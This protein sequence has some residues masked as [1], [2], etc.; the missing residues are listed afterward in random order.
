MRINAKKLDLIARIIEVD[1]EEILA[2]IKD[3]L[4]KNSDISTVLLNQEEEERIINALHESEA[5]YKAGSTHSRKDVE[6]YFNLKYS[7]IKL[8]LAKKLF[9]IDDKDLLNYIKAIFKSHFSADTWYEELPDEIRAN[10]DQGILEAE[11]SEGI[12]HE[13]V[14]KKYSKYL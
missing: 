7:N 13:E 8:N 9:N 5:D 14:M 1:N 4:N 12:S 2:K 10:V 6:D 11:K 3:V